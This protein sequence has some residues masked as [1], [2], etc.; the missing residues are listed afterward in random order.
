MLQPVS[1]PGNVERK[2]YHGVGLIVMKMAAAD[3]TAFETV[4]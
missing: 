2:D 3:C 4:P 1:I